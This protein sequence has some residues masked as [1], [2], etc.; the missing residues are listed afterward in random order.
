MTCLY[1][2]VGLLL[3][4]GLDLFFVPRSATPGEPRHINLSF[5]L[6]VGFPHTYL[7]Y[8]FQHWMP[9]LGWWWRVQQSV[10]SMLNSRISWINRDLNVYCAFGLFLKACLFQRLCDYTIMPTLIWIGCGILV[11]LCV[12]ER[13]FAFS[14][15]A[16]EVNEVPNQSFVGCQAILIATVPYSDR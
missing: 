16:H 14:S 7:P 13:G 6:F 3:G 1:I 4:S 15:L 10:I 8:N 9:W 5:I 11:L 12:S 2:L